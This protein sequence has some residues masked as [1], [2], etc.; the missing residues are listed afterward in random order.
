[1]DPYEPSFW[2]VLSFSVMPA[3]VSALGV[4]AGVFFAILLSGRRL[5]SRLKP[6]AE[7]SGALE[8]VRERYARGELSRQE[9]EQMRAVLEE[10]AAPSNLPVSSGTAPRAPRTRGACARR[11]VA[12]RGAACR[13][14]RG[15][16][17]FR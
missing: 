16:C 15:L 1:V 2:E 4:F 7:G 17:T 9:C 12:S 6:G 14:G 13:S 5:I 10:Q 3:L 11:S 8:I